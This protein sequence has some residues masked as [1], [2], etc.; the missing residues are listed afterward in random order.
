MNIA[1]LKSKLY[2]YGYEFV[3][4]VAESGEVSFRGDIM[5]I[6]APNLAKP[7]RVCFFDDEIESI[8]E[9]D[10][11]TQKAIRRSLKTSIWL[12]RF[13]RLAKRSLKS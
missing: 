5:D 12:R 9:F 3:D 7:L 13:W 11:D 8:R 4:I 1:A 6:F 2:G 10:V